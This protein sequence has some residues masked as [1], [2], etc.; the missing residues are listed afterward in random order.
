MEDGP[1]PRENIQFSIKKGTAITHGTLDPMEFLNG[2]TPSLDRSTLGRH[3]DVALDAK[4]L[5]ASVTA[6]VALEEHIR[7]VEQ[8]RLQ[9][10]ESDEALRKLVVTNTEAIR[11]MVTL[12][13]TLRKMEQKLEDAR[14]E[15]KAEGKAEAEEL[16]TAAA[17]A[18][19]D[20]AEEA[21]KE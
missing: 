8:L 12:E 20:M 11:K 18:A 15:G 16:A 9:K 13:E 1:W 4:L 10:A 6:S 14:R 19:A 21:R 17:K 3:D 2:A 5:Q 7:R